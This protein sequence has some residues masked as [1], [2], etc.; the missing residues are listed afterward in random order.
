MP[1]GRDVK[2]T[3]AGMSNT[4]GYFMI[5]YIGSSIWFMQGN[6]HFGT[7]VPSTS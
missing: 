5:C 3:A 1:I 4:V 7:T 6:R 2:I